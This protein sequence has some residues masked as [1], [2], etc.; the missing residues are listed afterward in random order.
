M[1]LIKLKKHPHNIEYDKMLVPVITRILK[2]IGNNSVSLTAFLRHNLHAI[3]GTFK[4]HN[5]MHFN[6][7]I[8]V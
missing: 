4:A 8:L 7:C 2:N 3:N 5:F 6:T 1:S